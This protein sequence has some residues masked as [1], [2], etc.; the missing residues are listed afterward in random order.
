MI[1]RPKT[2]LRLNGT[3]S[4]WTQVHS[5]LAQ[6]FVL[7]RLLFIIYNN[8]ID[9]NFLCSVA[10]FADDTKTDSDV[11]SKDVEQLQDSLHT[12]GGWC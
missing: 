5:A 12:L 10:K 4:R 6:G 1:T 9:V 8:D 3:A 11:G 7:G 2:S